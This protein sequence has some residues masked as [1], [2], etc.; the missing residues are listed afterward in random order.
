VKV[1]P[2]S[3]RAAPP[4]QPLGSCGKAAYNVSHRNQRGIMSGKKKIFQLAFW[5]LVM[6]SV[7]S[8]DWK[9][10]GAKALQRQNKVFGE[11]NQLRP[12]PNAVLIS[13]N[14]TYKTGAGVVDATYRVETA[15]TTAVEQWYVQEFAR[16]KWIA[17]SEEVHLSMRRKKFCRSGETA[18]LIFPQKAT[19]RDTQYQIQIGWGG[20][21]KC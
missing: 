3:E 5:I 13:K 6:V 14:S 4:W 17:L 1:G 11:F 10:N 19:E 12:L 2:T 8:I 18:I 7:F 20:P 16:L 21:F 9:M 15:G